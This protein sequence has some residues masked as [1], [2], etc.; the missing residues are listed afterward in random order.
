MQ[1]L[2]R[3]DA[4]AAS[5]GQPGRMAARRWNLC[6]SSAAQRGKGRRRVGQR[7]PRAGGDVATGGPW[8]R[9]LQAAAMA[10]GLD[11]AKR[12]NELC[13]RQVSSRGPSECCCWA[14]TCWMPLRRKAH[15]ITQVAKAWGS[16]PGLCGS[17]GRGFGAGLACGCRRSP[18]RVW[19]LRVLPLE[20]LP[21]ALTVKGAGGR[22]QQ[23]RTPLL[24]LTL[25]GWLLFRLAARQL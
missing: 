25:A 13:G 3:T 4:G 17:C 16:G 23:G 15:R 1:G 24:V 2:C 12:F 18:E 8:R 5:D 22:R 6:T 21:T 10:K 7:S 20:S 11:M 19:T 14:I 9:D